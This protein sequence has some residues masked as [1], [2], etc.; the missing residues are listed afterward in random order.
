MGYVRTCKGDRKFMS[1]MI[2]N[3]LFWADIP[4][5]DVIRVGTSFYMI[6]TTMHMMPGCPIMN[7]ENLA[8]WEIIG[9]VYDQIEDND[10]Y[11][12]Q[13]GENVYGQGQW[14]T[15]LRYH[16]G[17]FY[18]CF[19]CNDTQKFYVYQTQDIEG[20]ERS[21]EHTSELQSRGQLVCRL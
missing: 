17:T 13:D 5:I 11:N 3:P 10:A 7:S 4:D 18:L 12:L 2:K 1:T 6:S 20:G 21:E 16:E 15:S 8:D 19:S 14:A 9:Y